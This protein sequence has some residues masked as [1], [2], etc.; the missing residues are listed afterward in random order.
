MGDEVIDEVVQ[1]LYREHDKF[2]AV[3]EDRLSADLTR[4][5]EMLPKDGF[6]WVIAKSRPVVIARSKDTLFQI[7]L[8]PD[9]SRATITSRPLNCEKML[10]GLEWREPEP[11]P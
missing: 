3:A 10:V 7:V 1:E 5:L 11:E 8:H 2:V 4:A 9:E 6:D